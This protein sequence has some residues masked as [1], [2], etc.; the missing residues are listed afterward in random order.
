[1][2]SDKV[3]GRAA[4]AGGGGGGGRSISSE[5][6]SSG[7]GDGGGVVPYGVVF[8][9]NS[10]MTNGHSSVGDGRDGGGG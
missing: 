8:D 6:Q 7:S 10:F 9:S 5:F 3:D 2:R 1:M 4:G